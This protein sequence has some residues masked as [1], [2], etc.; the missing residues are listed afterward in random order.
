MRFASL[1]AVL[2]VLA[3]GDLP[4]EKDVKIVK[5]FEVPSYCEGIVFDHAG[6]GYISHGEV[7]TKFIPDGKHAVWA[8]TGAP[9]GHKVLADGRHLVGDGSQHAA[10][11]LDPGATVPGTAS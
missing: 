7:I 4:A 3:L 8:T 5:L 1:T 10:R 11:H 9:T 2:A 6:N